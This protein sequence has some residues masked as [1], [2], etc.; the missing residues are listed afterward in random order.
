M[1]GRKKRFVLVKD[2]NIMK[3]K[4]KIIALVAVTAGMFACMKPQN[5]IASGF[6]DAVADNGKSQD[7]DT[8]LPVVGNDDRSLPVPAASAVALTNSA[9]INPGKP[10]DIRKGGFNVNVH[11]NVQAPVQQ[12][13]PY[14]PG[15]WA[16]QT[17]TFQSGEFSF[18]N[19]AKDAMDEAVR[20]LAA[21]GCAVME[22]RLNWAQYTLV[23][24]APA[25]TSIEKYTSGQYG[26]NNEAKAE[27]QRTIAALK[28]SGKI[29][30]EA[31]LDWT[32]FTISYLERT[33]GGYEESWNTQ[34]FQS[35]QFSFNDE[36][37]SAMDE[38]VGQLNAA[39][40][41]IL[42]SRLNWAQYTLTFTAPARVQLQRYTSGQYG[43][44][45]EAK[46][47]MEQAVRAMKQS[48]KIVL[49]ARLNRAA[50]TISYL[51]RAYHPFPR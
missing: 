40:Y 29:I 33:G 27:M 26:F 32:V 15:P 44:S 43:F 6:R 37:K 14:Q 48:G 36:A 1:Q 42:E 21:A 34:T 3:T 8:T 2:G 35:G 20:Q 23:F 51:E 18:N 10:P 16:T 45:G 28:Q 25:R 22:S 31:R 19:E 46:A 4:I 49:E 5:A 13:Y 24:T 50:F 38:A 12:P 39:G 11:I 17:Y 7:F 47:G 9:A 30:L 41:P